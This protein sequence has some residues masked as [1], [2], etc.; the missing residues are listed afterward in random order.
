MET[1][2]HF[3]IKVQRSGK[4]P[5]QGVGYL[6]DGTMV[7]INGGGD[8]IGSTIPVNVLSVKHTSSGRIVFTNANQESQ[9]E[10]P[11]AELDGEGVTDA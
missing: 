10:N 11:Y 6:E 8:F 9:Q 5:M 3:D 2:E 1:G 7:V 4:E